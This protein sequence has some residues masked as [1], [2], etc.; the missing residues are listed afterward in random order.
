[1]SN[2]TSDPTRNWLCEQEIQNPKKDVYFFLVA[3]R[4]VPLPLGWISSARPTEAIQ[5]ELFGQRVTASRQGRSTDSCGQ[6]I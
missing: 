4:F 5:L 6:K 1:M 2:A 3:Q